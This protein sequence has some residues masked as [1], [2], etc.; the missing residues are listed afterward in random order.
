MTNPRHVGLNVHAESNAIAIAV[1]EPKGETRSIRIRVSRL[2]SIPASSP[3][4]LNRGEADDWAKL[5][6]ESERVNGTLI[7]ILW[8]EQVKTAFR[9]VFKLNIPWIVP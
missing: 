5:V 9:T 4:T 7:H 1:A 2:S 3:S 8:Y 6:G